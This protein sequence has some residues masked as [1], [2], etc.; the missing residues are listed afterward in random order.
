MRIVSLLLLS[1][2]S[3][4]VWFSAPRGPLR[5]A[6]EYDGMVLGTIASRIGDF[7]S[8]QSLRS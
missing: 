1:V 8:L 6:R 4:S 7:R 2:D 3:S 5:H